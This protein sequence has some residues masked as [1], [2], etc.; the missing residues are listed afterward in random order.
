MSTTLVMSAS[1]LAAWFQDL[2]CARIRPDILFEIGAFDA[3]FSKACRK[4]LSNR[5][6]RPQFHAFE[7]N[8]Y[9]F[10]AKHDKA[11]GAGIAYH[12][13]AVGDRVGVAEFRVKAARPK[14]GSSSLRT[15][16]EEEYEIVPVPITTLDAFVEREGLGGRINALWLDVEGCAYEVL[17]GAAR[18]LKSTSA[19]IVEVERRPHWHGQRLA[20]EV[21]ELLHAS[22]FVELAR[23]EEYGD[24]FNVVY[25]VP[26]LRT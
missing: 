20:H 9:V 5:D 24:Q 21:D 10:V 8:P 1:E 17:A 13:L 22:G 3:A 26:S 18:T 4:R 6:P 16:S 25:G 12:H 23:D 7:A 15:G 2:V 14:A 19:L 11:V